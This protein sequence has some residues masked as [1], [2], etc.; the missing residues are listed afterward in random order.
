MKFVCFFLFVCVYIHTFLYA[1]RHISEFIPVGKS[2]IYTRRHYS[3]LKTTR[4][5]YPLYLKNIYVSI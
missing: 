1:N 3:S 2:I 4:T 5:Y